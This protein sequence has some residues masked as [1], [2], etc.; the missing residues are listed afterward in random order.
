MKALTQRATISL[1]RKAALGM[2]IAALY[3]MPHAHAQGGCDNDGCTVPSAP[4]ISPS[5]LSPLLSSAALV[6]GAVVVLRSRRR[7]S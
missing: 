6:G 7:R 4:E 2:A 3:A 5:D 1:L